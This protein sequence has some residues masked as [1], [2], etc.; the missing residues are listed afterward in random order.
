M[1]PT[2]KMIEAGAEAYAANLYGCRDTW[3][4]MTE[5]QRAFCHEVAEGVLCAALADVPEPSG[6][7]QPTKES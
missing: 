5:P 7:Q 4:R 1:K 6:F 3:E 2:K